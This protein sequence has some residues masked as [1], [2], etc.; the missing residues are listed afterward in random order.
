ME[1]YRLD[2]EDFDQELIRHGSFK[3]TDYQYERLRKRAF[4]KRTSLGAEIRNC[5]NESFAREDLEKKNKSSVSAVPLVSPRRKDIL[6]LIKHCRKVN[7]ESPFEIDGKNGFINQVKE[8][9]L[10]G[11]VWSD[12]LL[13]SLSKDIQKGYKNYFYQ[14]DSEKKLGEIIKVMDLSDKQIKVFRKYLGSPFYE[15]ENVEVEF[16]E[17]EKWY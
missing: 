7:E 4:D 14:Q 16:K 10:F 6:K 1:S 3:M 9:K 12:N 11:L 17:E 15:S 5:I 13:K 2:I 8:Q